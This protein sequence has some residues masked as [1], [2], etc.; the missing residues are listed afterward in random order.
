MPDGAL[1]IRGARVLRPGADPHRPPV[2]DV[3]IAGDRIAAIRTAHDPPFDLPVGA[4]MIEGAGRLLIPGLV[5]AHY[6]SYDAL[7]KGRFEDM[8]FDV[9][10]LHSQPAYLGRRSKAELRART[11]LGAMEALKAGIT[12]IQDMNS[13]VPQ[14]EETLD[15]ILS[16]YAE[17]GIRVVFSI[18]LRDLPDLDIAPF[19][20]PDLPPDVAALVGGAPRDPA[21]DLAFV[22][23]QLKRLAPLPPRLHWA[24]SPSGPQR[25]S[26]ALLEG[27]AELSARYHLPVFTHVYETRAQ[28]AKARRIYPDGSMIRHM[29]EVG[30][31]TPRTTIAH[32]V[33]ITD[34]EIALLAQ[35]GT[36]VVLNPVSNLKLKNGVAPLVAMKRAGVR[37]ALG[38]DNNSCSDCQ[39]LFQAMKMFALLA[40][41]ADANPTGVLACDAVEAATAGGAQAVALPDI[42]AVAPGMK[43]D[44]VLLDLDDLAWQPF[45]SAARQLVHCETGRG[46]QT[47]IVDGRVVLRGGRLTTVNEAA[48]RAELAEVMEELERDHAALSARAAPA[49]PVLLEANEKL[50]RVDLGMWRLVGGA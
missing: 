29:A 18:A 43:A 11:L 42:G 26:R 7:L 30:L 4:E 20:P 28:L 37:L 22:E 34:D 24:L 44:L 46:V 10:A 25:S 16:A 23:A 36:G 3:L 12:T 41:G 48:F 31:L 1:L 45:A 49:I 33:H 14:D 6:H 38:C 5:S 39:N 32:A 2:A 15:I 50:S 19:L 13:L 9:W 21:A 8:P 17:V 40:S 27:I 47:V 35:A